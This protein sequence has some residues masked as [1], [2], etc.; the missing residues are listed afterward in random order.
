MLAFAFS[1]AMR[2]QHGLHLAPGFFVH[3]GLMRPDVLHPLEGDDALVVG[4][5]QHAMQLGTRHRLGRL[6]GR[7]H[8]RQPTIVQVRS[9]P[10][11]RPL[12]RRILRKRQPDERCPL[13][14][15]SDRPDFSP[16]LVSGTDVHV[17]EWC[18][19]QRPTIPG[20]LAHPLHDLIGEIPTVELGDGAHDAVQQHPTRRLVDVLAGRHQPHTSVFEGPVYLHI[21]RPVSR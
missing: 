7:R 1:E 5:A 15:Q 21:V 20:F 2:V 9:E 19:T 14:I 4:V 8:G 6:T 12:S 3:Q 16:V 11:G 10:L 18:L 17:A 13:L